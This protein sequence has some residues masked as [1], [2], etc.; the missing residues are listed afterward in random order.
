LFTISADI[1][2]LVCRLA[3]ETPFERTAF[4]GSAL[5]GTADGDARKFRDYGRYESMTQSG[6]DEFVHRDVR[7]DK[8]CLAIGI[9][10]YDFVQVARINHL[11]LLE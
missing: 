4:T 7:L 5:Y 11:T 1:F 6:I 2:N 3:E 10:R 9:N 8:G